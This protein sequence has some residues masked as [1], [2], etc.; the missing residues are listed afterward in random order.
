MSRPGLFAVRYAIKAR[1]LVSIVIP[2]RDQPDLLRTT[3]DSIDRLSS[4]GNRELVIIDNGSC[5]EGAIR[6]LRELSPVHV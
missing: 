2:T 6:Y 1:P 4:W 3:I 5:E